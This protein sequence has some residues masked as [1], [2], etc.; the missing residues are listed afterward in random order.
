M[1]RNPPRN[2]RAHNCTQTAEEKLTK[3]ELSMCIPGRQTGKQ[4]RNEILV[5]VALK[6]KYLGMNICIQDKMSLLL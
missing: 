2:V 6:E 5:T 1:L 3:T 4:I